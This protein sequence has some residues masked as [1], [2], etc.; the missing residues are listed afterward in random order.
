[1]KVGIYITL[2]LVSLLGCK[3]TDTEDTID[4]P[5][6]GEYVSVRDIELADTGATLTQSPL[7]SWRLGF[8][9]FNSLEAAL[10]SSATSGVADMKEWHDIG[11]TTQYTIA[12][13]NLVECT[14]YYPMLRAKNATQILDSYIVE[15]FSVDLTAPTAPISISITE[16]GLVGR[17]ATATWPA[18]TD[19]CSVAK[20]S[21]AIGSTSGDDDILT[22]TDV[23]GT[24][25]QAT[26]G[27]SLQ[28]GQNYYSSVIAVDGADQQ[29]LMRTSSAWRLR[30][31]SAYLTGTQ[32]LASADFNS[33]SSYVRWSASTVNSDY[34]SH[35]VVTNPETLTVLLAGD[36]ILHLNMPFIVSSGCTTRCSVRASVVVNGSAREDAV[37][38]SSYVIN[39][40]GFTESSNHGVF[41][42]RNLSAGD[43]IRLYTEKGTPIVGTMISE[44]ISAYF[45]YV[46]PNRSFFYGKGQETTNSTNFNDATSYGIEW[47]EQLA[48][49]DY[50]HSAI[51]PDQVVL[52]TAGNYF[53]AVNLPLEATGVCTTRNNV[54]MDV[55]LDGV[56]VTGGISNQGGVDCT[57]S[58]T[59]ASNHW[60]GVLSG[61]TAGQ[62]LTV[63]T[64]QEA[65]NSV[66][67][68]QPL[69]KASILVE[70]L[71]S[72]ENIISLT[73]TRTV[74]STNW[75]LAASQ[76]QWSAQSVY[77]SGAYTHST[78]VNSHQITVNRTG[79]YMLYFNDHLTSVTVRPNV[80]VRVQKNGVNIVGAACSSNIIT[81]S[82]SNNESTCAMSLYLEN[83]TAGDV[84]TLTAT[85]EAAAATVTALTPARVTLMRVR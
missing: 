6:S 15:P 33:G 9:L 19:N 28:F 39:T 51:I 47:S 5:S 77:D 80:Q 38:N 2:I 67:E 18:G 1:M 37:A 48:S 24:T 7:M 3:R 75:N 55:R 61:V 64:V 10:S 32:T 78:G 45:E 84:I 27:V 85:R 30:S 63:Q 8:P 82:N 4:T 71:S 42:L 41:Y 31:P 57:S 74:G 70:K 43:Q 81:N 22:W 54:K 44:G 46:Y 49:A 58:H 73:G 12:G 35:S 20:Y 11:V 23:S 69:K 16:D 13:L 65:N 76:I 56:V 79:S 72:I 66:L 40:A 52:D 68:I 59:T 36:Y 50:T 21:F 17:S 62:V 34:F 29:S 83:V 26:S 14:N 25:H 53:V 60:F